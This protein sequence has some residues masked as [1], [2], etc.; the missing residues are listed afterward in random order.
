MNKAPWPE[1]TVKLMNE[2]QKCGYVHP[3]TC[4]N[5]REDLVARVDG[6][7]CNGCE[8]ITQDTTGLLP[9]SS[10]PKSIFGGDGGSVI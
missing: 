4:N 1:D 2:W 8:A 6:W 7:W 9:I 5:C 10:P 3:Y